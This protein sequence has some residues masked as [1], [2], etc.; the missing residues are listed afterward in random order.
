MASPVVQ[1]RNGAVRGL[2]ADEVAVFRGVP[3]AL[4]PIGPLRWRPPQPVPAW[5]GVRE[6]NDWG[7]VAMQAIKPSVAGLPAPSEDCLTLNVFA[8]AEPPREP[9]PVMVW[10]HG[11]GFTE[12]ASS[13]PG[14]DG[15]FLVRQ[16]VVLVSINY[17]LGRFG[18]FAHPALTWEAQ[19]EPLANYGL[20]DQMAAL[21]WVRDNIAAFG[22][23]RDNITVFGGSAGATSVLALMVS[24]AARGLFDKAISQSAVARDRSRTLAEAEA[25]GAVLAAK[26]GV[27]EATTEALRAVPADTILAA[28]ADDPNIVAVSGQAPIIDGTLLR[29]QIDVA[30][31]AGRQSPAPLLIGT[32]DFELPTQVVPPYLAARA[33]PYADAGA[34]LRRIYPDEASYR[35][36]LSDALFGEPAAH[37]AA[38]HARR[39]PTWLYRFSILTPSLQQMGFT[40]ALHSAE[41]PYVFGNLAASAWPMTARDHDLADEVRAYWTAFASTGRPEP[42]GAPPWPD[43]TSGELMEFTNEGPVAVTD[44]RQAVLHALTA[45]YAA[46]ELQLAVGA[47]AAGGDGQG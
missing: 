47:D 17:R 42:A 37:I 31:A 6:A 11:G 8:P 19:G 33:R 30:F 32:T 5:T 12:G 46:G 40:G 27:R 7:H 16:G 21:R 25:A 24:P 26:W 20:M 35:R 3:F 29:E 22:G 1:T 28:E 39:H 13:D 9:L 44:D 34:V 2:M 15:S 10:I 45:A 18:F 14:A 43:V 36:Y 23:E 38:L 4:P 41:S